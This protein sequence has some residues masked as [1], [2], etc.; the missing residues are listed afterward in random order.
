M[1][2]T[3]MENKGLKPAVSNKATMK[4]GTKASGKSCTPKK[5]G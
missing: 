5:K 4:T 2:K 1:D 3:K